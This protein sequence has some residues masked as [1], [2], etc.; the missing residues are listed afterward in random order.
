MY[1][2][3][4]GTPS[5]HHEGLARAQPYINYRENLLADEVVKSKSKV[6]NKC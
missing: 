1:Y 3:R 5:Q 6:D 4:E 2:L